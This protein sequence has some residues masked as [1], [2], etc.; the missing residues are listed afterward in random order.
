MNRSLLASACS[1]LGLLLSACGATT[2]G[3]AAARASPWLTPGTGQ[4]NAVSGSSAERY[5]PLVDGMV[6][7]YTTV[8]EVGE[9]GLLVAR[10]HRADGMRGEL[11][12][13]GSGVK[14]FEILPDGIALHARNGE[15]SY[16]LKLPLVVGT[17]WRGE[18]GG[19]SRILNTELTMDTPAG[20]YETC[21]QTME[22]RL[23]DR[24]TRFSTTFCPGVGVVQI[25][26]ATGA[27]F[28]RALLKSY[29]P[30]MR[31]REDGTEKLPPAAP[32]RDA[33]ASEAQR[34]G[35]LSSPRTT[36]PSSS[37]TRAF[38]SGGTSAP[39]GPWST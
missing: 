26:V 38:T 17:T 2:D 15:T 4:Q 10:V 31:M 13:P 1:A 9:Q 27:N 32:R 37:A 18:H 21:V 3:A 12:F 39:W 16:V 8:N 24:P 19:Q 25:D 28:E 22:E 35:I 34:T 30:P 14:G 7:T 33:R 36:R 23:G 11:R 29:A 6:Y 20:H 5:F